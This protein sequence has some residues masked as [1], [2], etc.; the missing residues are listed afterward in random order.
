MKKLGIIAAVIVVLFAILI[1]LNNLSNKEKLKD[2]PY[3]TN[4]LNQST[5]DL[6][7]NENY[8]NIILPEA[9]EVKIE[10]GKPVIAYLFSPECS[11]CMNFTPTLMKTAKNVGIQVDQ[12]NI[13]EYEKGWDVYDVEATPTLIYFNDGKEVNRI[14]GDYSQNVTEL[15]KFLEQAKES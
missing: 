1:I 4:N 6:L 8:Q 2:N 7:D 3:G 12:L 5:I 13:L 10:S 14:V 9:L 11:H 15:T